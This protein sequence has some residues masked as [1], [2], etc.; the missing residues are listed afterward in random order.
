MFYIPPKIFSNSKA[1]EK[2]FYLLVY[3]PIRTNTRKA[4]ITKSR[5][6]VPI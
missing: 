2:L 4:A 5:L 6:P 1:L 3:L